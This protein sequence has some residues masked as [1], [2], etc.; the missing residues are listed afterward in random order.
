MQAL[1]A[2]FEIA[3][4]TAEPDS[5][6]SLE[7]LRNVFHRREV[8]RLLLSEREDPIPS[9]YELITT[10][11]ITVNARLAFVMFAAVVLNHNALLFPKQVAFSDD[12]ILLE[13]PRKIDRFV[14]RR[15]WKTET[16]DAA[17]R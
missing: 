6:Q 7:I 17:W 2:L 15:R 12:C 1:S 16:P 3:R 4:P 9:P 13:F 8:I 11:S 14:Q 5:E 10:T